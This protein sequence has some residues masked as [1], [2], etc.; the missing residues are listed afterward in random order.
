[1][2][3]DEEE[4][5]AGVVDGLGLLP[6][7][8]TFDPDKVLARAGGSA[9][10]AAVE[11][12]QIHHGRTSIRHATGTEHDVWL[13]LGSHPDG[14]R[15]GRILGTTLHGLFERDRFRRS[16]LSWVATE[17]RTSFAPST[18]PFAT[19]REEAFDRLADTIEEHVD[20]AR[21]DSL[22]GLDGA[23]QTAA[24]PR[25]SARPS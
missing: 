23:G 24:R 20:M 19:G 5:G 10:G 9:F 4:S 25:R 2:I 17:Q 8:T 14:V 6:V 18:K 7:E 15:R 12:Y 16:F 13:Y 3:H 22:I 11:G 21:I 1:M